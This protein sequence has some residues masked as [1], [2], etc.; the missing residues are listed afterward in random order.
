MVVGSCRT[1]SPVNDLDW[2]IA[3]PPSDEAVV[4][5][6][7]T[8]S[9]ITIDLDLAF[10]PETSDWGGLSREPE[11][12]QM[13]QFVQAFGHTLENKTNYRMAFLVD[14]RDVTDAAVRSFAPLTNLVRTTTSTFE[15][16]LSKRTFQ[17]IDSVDLLSALSII[18]CHYQAEATLDGRLLRIY[19]NYHST[20]PGAWQTKG[21]HIVLPFWEDPF[22][23][24]TREA[25]QPPRS[26][27]L[28]A[29]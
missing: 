2:P 21:H 7:N 5:L 22:L 9:S 4:I 20:G 8:L 11:K 10:N 1:P 23:R 16:A 18:L 12:A 19:V 24:H 6:T 26:D 28:N 17:S 3:S 27:R 13:E 25:Q 29:R 14:I 15:V